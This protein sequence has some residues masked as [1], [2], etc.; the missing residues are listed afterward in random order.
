MR[1]SFDFFAIFQDILYLLLTLLFG[2]IGW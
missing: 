1:E 2:Y